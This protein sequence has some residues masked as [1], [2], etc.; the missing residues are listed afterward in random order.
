VD[1]FE[2]HYKFEKNE[3][4]KKKMIDLIII[5]TICN[6]FILFLKIK[7]KIHLKFF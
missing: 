4:I 1:N 6:S 3:K 2:K 7:L 5:V